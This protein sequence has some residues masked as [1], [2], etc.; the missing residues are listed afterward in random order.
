MSAKTFIIFIVILSAISGGVYLYSYDLG[1]IDGYETGYSTGNIDGYRTGLEEGLDSG[2]TTGFD[3]GNSSGYNVGFVQGNEEGYD[4]GFTEGNSEGTQTGFTEG[5]YQG[6]DLGYSN[7]NITGYSL[8]YVEGNLTGHHE[9]LLHGNETGFDIGYLSGIVDGLDSGYT[10]RNPTYS[11]VL[12]F[13]W[14]DKTDDNDYIDDVYVCRHFSSDVVRHAYEEGYRSFYVYIGFGNS[15]HAIVGFNTTDRG[16][17]YYEPQTDDRVYPVVGNV[18]WDRSKYIPPPYDDK[19][20]E[21][22]IVG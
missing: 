3:D 6:Y 20:T 22:L 1:A 21:I 18:Y 16:M 19:I 8:G 7:G 4:T 11:E 17:I 2:Y 9:G 15:S 12:K 13:M 10:I 5:H 14:D